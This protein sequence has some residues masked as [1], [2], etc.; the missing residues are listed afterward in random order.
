MAL[1]PI[2]SVNSATLSARST[3]ARPSFVVPLIKSAQGKGPWLHLQLKLRNKSNRLLLYR[4]PDYD[5]KRLFRLRPA[6]TGILSPDDTQP[7]DLILNADAGT[8]SVTGFVLL[9]QTA[10]IEKS[11]SSSE[12]IVDAVSTWQNVETSKVSSLGIP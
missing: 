6:E 7:F 1:Q 9:I 8:D 12:P 2:V 3:P 11:D 10:F 5:E 4:V